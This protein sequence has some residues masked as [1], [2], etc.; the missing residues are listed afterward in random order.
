MLRK[1]AAGVVLISIILA[2]TA[3]ALPMPT[4]VAPQDSAPEPSPKSATPIVIKASTNVPSV[5]EVTGL[6]VGPGRTNP[7]AQVIVTAN[8]LNI[9][10]TEGRYVAELEIDDIVE[11]VKEK[12]IPAGETQTFNFYVSRKEPGIYEVSCGGLVSKFEVIDVIVPTQRDSFTFNTAEQNVP[13][14]PSCCAPNPTPVVKP[15]K[16]S[17]CN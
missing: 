11:D 16:P 3:C 12:A 9:G 10:D 15:P 14:V 7:G 4:P 17:C 13:N 6:A 2:F 5:F 8:I 1:T